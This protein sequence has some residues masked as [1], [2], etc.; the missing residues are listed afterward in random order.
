MS[1]TCSKEFSLTIAQGV[2][3]LSYWKLD[4]TTGN[5]LDSHGSNHLVPAGANAFAAGKISNAL[6]FGTVEAELRKT[7]ISGGLL[8]T[9]PFTICGWYQK[10]GVPLFANFHFLSFQLYNGAHTMIWRASLRYTSA[11]DLQFQYGLGASG[12]AITTITPVIGTWYFFRLW[13][14]ADQKIHAQF[15]NGLKYDGT[16]VIGSVPATTTSEVVFGPT[17][18]Y[19]LLLD[20]IGIYDGEM[21]DA[22][23][24]ALYNSGNGNTY[25]NVP[26]V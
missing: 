23:A 15:N 10:T 8:T 7:G 12:D 24:A 13:L 14:G 4:E 18:V 11:G 25:P 2:T 6:S 1:K 19:S 22:S 21:N 5:R 20:E 17:P 3:L 16:V 26:G 9:A